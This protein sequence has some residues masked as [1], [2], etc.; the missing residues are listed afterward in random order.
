MWGT[1]TFQTS[2]RNGLQH[3]HLHFFRADESLQKHAELNR[4]KFQEIHHLCHIFRR[5]RVPVGGNGDIIEVPQI[6][7]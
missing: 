4:A 5:N 1:S 6:P 3:H 7:T 2:K